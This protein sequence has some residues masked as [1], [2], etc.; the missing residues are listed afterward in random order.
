MQ[1]PQ[2]WR[3]G[4]LRR[5]NVSTPAESAPIKTFWAWD[6]PSSNPTRSICGR[7][8]P[9]KIFGKFEFYSVFFWCMPVTAGKYK[10]SKIC[11]MA[12]SRLWLP[13]C[14]SRVILEIRPYSSRVLPYYPYTAVYRIHC[15]TSTH[16][17]RSP[18]FFTLIARARVRYVRY[19]TTNPQLAHLLIPRGSFFPAP[20]G[21]L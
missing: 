7:K 13:S 10:I 5:Q 17:K 3:C 4:P 8:V 1:V 19:D 14:C 6:P 21:R 2:Q 20:P 16:G 9:R 11:K 12:G 15:S 18:T